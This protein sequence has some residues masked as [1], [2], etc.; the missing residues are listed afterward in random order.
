[1]LS[2]VLKLGKAEQ[3][4]F[5]QHVVVVCLHTLL[6]DPSVDIFVLC[7]RHK[8]VVRSD[9]YIRLQATLRVACLWP[10]NVIDKSTAGVVGKRLP[11]LQSYAFE[12]VRDW[13]RV[14]AARHHAIDK[15]E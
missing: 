12:W 6:L 2:Q 5:L 7:T 10:S 8:W 1:M 11:T 4:F 3:C 9:L 15:V 13:I 14:I